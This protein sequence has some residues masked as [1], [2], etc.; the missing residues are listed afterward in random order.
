MHKAYKYILLLFPVLFSMLGCNK[1]EHYVIG[2]S[3]SLDDEW[4]SRMNEEMR[5]EALLYDNI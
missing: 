4:R 3:Q 1:Q 2:F 5:Q